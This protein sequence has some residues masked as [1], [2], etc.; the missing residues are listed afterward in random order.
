MSMPQTLGLLTGCAV[1][2]LRHE[3]GGSHFKMVH[4]QNHV[5]QMHRRWRTSQ[6][7]TLWRCPTCP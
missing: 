1:Y 7:C 6:S 2:K 4:M 5:Q 3:H